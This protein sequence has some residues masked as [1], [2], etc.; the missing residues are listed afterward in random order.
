[1]KNIQY[2]Y[3]KYTNIRYINLYERYCIDFVSSCIV[4]F[5]Y[6]MQASQ[7]FYIFFEKLH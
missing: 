7:L 4:Y 5:I 1:M 3:G 6:C 2:I